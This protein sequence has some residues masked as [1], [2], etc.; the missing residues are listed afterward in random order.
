V[1]FAFISLSKNKK[2]FFLL[3]DDSVTTTIVYPYP[4]CWERTLFL[5]TG[6]RQK[7]IRKQPQTQVA[8][9]IYT[10]HEKIAET[11]VYQENYQIEVKPLLYIGLRLFLTKKCLSPAN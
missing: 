2:K 11:Q 5:L 6:L 7:T 1:G 9:G 4:Y 10:K 3:E 8:Q